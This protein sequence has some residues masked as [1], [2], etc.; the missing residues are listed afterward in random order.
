MHC[1][2][3]QCMSC[4]L[5]QISSFNILFSFTDLRA[6]ACCQVSEIVVES[7]E[8]PTNSANDWQFAL[9]ELADSHYAAMCTKRDCS[10]KGNI[11]VLYYFYIDMYGNV[12]IEN[13]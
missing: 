11:I 10:V 9:W 2:V 7:L 8:D 1:A 4:Y 3:L 5:I 6:R 12:K 13:A